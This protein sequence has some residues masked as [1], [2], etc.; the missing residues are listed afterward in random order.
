MNGRSWNSVALSI[1]LKR[2]NKSS[3]HIRP[4]TNWSSIAHQLTRQRRWLRISF[5][6]CHVSRTF[7]CPVTTRK[8]FHWPRIPSISCTRLKWKISSTN[9]KWS[10]W[11]GSFRRVQICEHWKSIGS[12][13]T[14]S[15]KSCSSTFSK[16]ANISKFFNSA[17]RQ[18]RSSWKTL[19]ST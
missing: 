9:P 8:F 12:V 4:S 7:D 3:L 1:V 14:Q 17:I 19:T 10:Q 11:T 18:I 5:T 13:H 2:R 15:V 6:S 16:M